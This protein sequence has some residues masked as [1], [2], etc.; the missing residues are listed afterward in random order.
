MHLE[1]TP[2]QCYFDSVLIYFLSVAGGMNADKVIH[3]NFIRH[4]M[5]MVL[6][7]LLCSVILDKNK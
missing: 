5:Y 2:K 6:K 3:M 7:V 1:P 4:M